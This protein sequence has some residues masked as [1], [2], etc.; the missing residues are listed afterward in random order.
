MGTQTNRSKRS[1]DPMTRPPVSIIVCAYNAEKDI[2]E[3]LDSL[4]AQTRGIE[5]LVKAMNLTI[6]VQGSD[7]LG[8]PGSASAQ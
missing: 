2:S 6:E 3:T 1:D 4:I 5:G 8:K 7:S